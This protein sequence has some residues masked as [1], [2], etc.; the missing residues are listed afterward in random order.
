MCNATPSSELTGSPAEWRLPNGQDLISFAL[1]VGLAAGPLL[2]LPGNVRPMPG[3]DNRV[4]PVPKP[5]PA[6]PEHQPLPDF[7]G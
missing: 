3:H 1:G 6:A 2:S 4:K 5:L 7:E